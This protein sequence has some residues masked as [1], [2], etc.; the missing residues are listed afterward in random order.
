MYTHTYSF[1][2]GDDEELPFAMY[3]LIRETLFSYL[4]DRIFC[5]LLT[6]S[7]RPLTQSGNNASKMSMHMGE[8]QGQKSKKERERKTLKK[9]S[10][11]VLLALR[12]LSVAS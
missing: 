1:E 2:F 9:F 6:A 5:V 11:Q 7:V 12:N 10:R 8:R 3:S 4:F